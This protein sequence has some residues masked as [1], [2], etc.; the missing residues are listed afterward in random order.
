MAIPSTRAALLEYTEKGAYTHEGQSPILRLRL[1]HCCPRSTFDNDSFANKL[2]SNSISLRI[3]PI[4]AAE[5]HLLGYM[6]GSHP[7]VFLESN[8]SEAHA[9]V[10]EIADGDIEFRVG[11]F[12]TDPS[13]QS[14]A[15]KRED[16]SPKTVQVWSSLARA[17]PLRNALLA[18]YSSKNAAATLPMGHRMRFIP[19]IMSDRFIIA[20]DERRMAKKARSKQ[21]RFLETM[22]SFANYQIVGLRYPLQEYGG[23]TLHEALSGLR[24][25]KDPDTALFFTME[26]LGSK[27]VFIFHKDRADEAMPMIPALPRVMETMIGPNIW[28]W[29]DDSAKADCAGY[30]FDLKR[31]V[32][33]TEPTFD[34]DF[35][36]WS[37]ADS[38][39]DEAPTASDA[40]FSLQLG[41]TGAG[42]WDDSSMKTAKAVAMDED[43]EPPTHIFQSTTSPLSSSVS[44]PSNA[45]IL[46]AAR[47]DPTLLAELLSIATS[48]PS[49]SS[50]A[51]SEPSDE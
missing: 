37:D 21:T 29:F 24:S 48:Q 27:V 28:P 35:E 40:A 23:T 8:W 2:G 9:M 25:R 7:E 38:Y 19:N 30:A 44:S 32:F 36:E 5:E 10:P 3:C 22:I 6:L 33:S 41:L 42:Q 11:N 46:Q 51:V 14:W 13:Q 26:D 34:V 39:D 47:N 31:G 50:A 49:G 20:D 43:V 12:D 18:L 16:P 15:S 45:A 17:R 4:Q 1:G